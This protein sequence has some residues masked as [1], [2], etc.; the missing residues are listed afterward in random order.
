MLVYSAGLLHD[1]HYP[2]EF[3]ELWSSMDWG[4]PHYPRVFIPSLPKELPHPLISEVVSSH[5][6]ED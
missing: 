4:G 6:T 3:C 5:Q 1:L 2:P